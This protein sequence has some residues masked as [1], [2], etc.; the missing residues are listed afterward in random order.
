MRVGIDPG[1]IVLVPGVLER[2]VGVADI[3]KQISDLGTIT[4]PL[5]ERW[6]FGVV[7]RG[8][9]RHVLTP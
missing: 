8:N 3:W 5:R 2:D 4:H 6:D 7:P 9:P 1:I